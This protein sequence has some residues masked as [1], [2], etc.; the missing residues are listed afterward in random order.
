MRDIGATT[1]RVVVL[2]EGESD[3]RAVLALARRLAMD[4]AAEGVEVID[5]GGVTNLR[6]HFAALDRGTD[7][8]RVV[9]LYDIGEFGVVRRMLDEAGRG[10]PEDIAEA[11]RSEFFACSIDLEDELIR[12]AGVGLVETVLAEVGELRDS[13][14]SRGSTQRDRPVEAQLRRF[15]GTA[16]GRKVRFSAALVERLPLERCPRSSSRCCA[17]SRLSGLTPA[18]RGAFGPRGARATCSDGPWPR[19]RR[20]RARRPPAAPEKFNRPLAILLAMA[21]FV[22]VVDT[23]IMNVSISAVVRDLGTTASG[24]QGAIALEASSRRRSSSSAERPAT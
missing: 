9:G 21:M 11:S 5:M 8:P 24:V 16:S 12:A 10:L 15:A 18:S 6:H 1:V 14:R 19:H 7:P 22:L 4:L 17:P 2:V 23:S 13:G 20:V 3:R